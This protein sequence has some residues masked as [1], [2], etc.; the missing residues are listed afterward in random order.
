MVVVDIRSQ[1]LNPRF[2]RNMNTSL[3]L[4]LVIE[5]GKYIYAEKRLLRVMNSCVFRVEAND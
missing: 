4:R 3:N 1:M 2:I 5:L